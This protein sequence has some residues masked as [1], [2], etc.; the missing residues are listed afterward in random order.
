MYI[1][2]YRCLAEDLNCIEALRM[3]T[4]HLLAREGR[5]DEAADRI[6]ELIQLIDRFEPN[7]HALYYDTSLAFA[8]MVRM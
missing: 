2:M 7:N 3:L 5:Y 6:G 4:L 1:H 8:R